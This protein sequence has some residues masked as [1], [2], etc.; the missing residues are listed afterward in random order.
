[1]CDC[2]NM[3]KSQIIYKIVLSPPTGGWSGV[4][5]PH[6]IVYS[7]KFNLQ[8]ESPR[9][10][11][12]LLLSWK[13]FP[14]V[15][16]YDSACGLATHTNSR[17][18]D[19]PPFHPHEGKPVAPTQENLAKAVRRTLKMPLLWLTEKCEHSEENGHPV[20]GSNHHYALHEKLHESNT[21]DPHNVLRGV[22]LVPEL[23]D[24]VKSKAVKHLFADLRKNNY[25]FNSM[26]TLH[27]R[28]PHEEPDRTQE[29]IL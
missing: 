20:T 23:Q 1:M 11:A 3:S 12:D 4:A 7:L 21:K 29:H 18:P 17:V 9:D 8:T 5:C 24:I 19:D 25:F 2:E 6:G 10:F 16:L 22:D 15:C 26:A 28:I 13:H 27:T 14:N